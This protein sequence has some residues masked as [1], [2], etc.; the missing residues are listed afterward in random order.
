MRLAQ[1]SELVRSNGWGS[2]MKELVFLNRTAIVVEKD[3]SDVKERSA[4]LQSSE[5][6]LVEIDN[7]MLSSGRYRFAVKNRYLKALNHLKHG[8]GG[9]A[10]A[11]NDVVVGDTWHYTSEATNDPN[12]LHVDLRRFGFKTWLKNYVYTFDIFVA[13]GERKDGVSAAFQNNAMLWLRSRGYTKAFGFYWA[14]NLP[15]HWCTRVTNKW[16]KI[17]SVSISRF[18]MFTKAST[19]KE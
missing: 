2:L 18:L 14:D 4:P 15:A 1:M 13:P 9:L 16:K 8:Y 10:I 3:L 5:L 19:P 12:R 6:K 11:R 17:R 7:Q